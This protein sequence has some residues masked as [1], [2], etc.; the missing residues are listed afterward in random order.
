MDESQLDSEI[1][2]MGTTRRIVFSTQN[3][4]CAQTL[5]TLE[6]GVVSLGVGPATRAGPE[7]ETM[8]GLGHPDP[9]AVQVLRA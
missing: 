2:G 9:G 6:V 1:L 4:G 7:L 3:I 8:V 5:T